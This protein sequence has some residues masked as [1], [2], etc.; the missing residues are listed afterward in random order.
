[1]AATVHWPLIIGVFISFNS[2]LLINA[3]DAS[4]IHR[5]R[6][7]FSGVRIHVPENIGSVLLIQIWRGHLPNCVIERMFATLVARR[8]MI[9]VKSGKSQPA[10]NRMLTTSASCDHAVKA[11]RREKNLAA[12]SVNS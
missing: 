5:F 1:M 2:H 12:L 6:Y 9:A 11:K 7:T 3:W 4:A 8:Q 10:T